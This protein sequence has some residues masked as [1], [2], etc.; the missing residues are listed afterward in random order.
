MAPWIVTAAAL[1]AVVFLV[2]RLR[3]REAELARALQRGAVLDPLTGVLGRRGFEERLGEEV[4]RAR[5]H[6]RRLALVVA[7]VDG[8]RD[9]NA[10]LGNRAGDVALEQVGC[11]LRDAA[12][13]V[14]SVARVD[15]GEYAVLLPD[16]DE[17]GALALAERL[18]VE[19]REAFAGGMA[20]LTASFG[21]ATYPKDAEQPAALMQ[22]AASALFLAKELGRNRAVVYSDETA[23]Q[24]AE[25]AAG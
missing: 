4:E 2:L 20:E 19:I 5:R 14:D 15:G 8:L 18:R 1:A 25:L 11:I 16:T 10:L 9:L 24:L 23:A 3:R 17:R 21:V 12:R 7:D 6:G 13:R 22:A